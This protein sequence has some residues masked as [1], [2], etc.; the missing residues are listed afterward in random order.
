MRLYKSNQVGPT[1][2]DLVKNQ[3]KKTSQNTEEASLSMFGLNN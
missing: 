1:A 2:R 3:T